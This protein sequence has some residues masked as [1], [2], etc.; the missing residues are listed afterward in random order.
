MLEIQFEQHE[1]DRLKKLARG[2]H[3]TVLIA[4]LEKVKAEMNNIDHITP[5]NLEGYKIAK[6]V[7]DEDML[8]FFKNSRQNIEEETTGEYE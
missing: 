8:T 1:L 5:E 2:Y 4:F 3:G 7:I 6:T